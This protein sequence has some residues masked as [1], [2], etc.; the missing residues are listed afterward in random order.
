MVKRLLQKSDDKTVRLWSRNGKLLYTQ[1][2]HN[3]EVRGVSFS[4]DGKII[5]TGSMDGTI[6]LW[7]INGQELQTFTGHQAGIINIAFSPDGKTLA[8]AIRDK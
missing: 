2:R 7:S 1:K 3:D 8:S 5:A 4:L 6:K